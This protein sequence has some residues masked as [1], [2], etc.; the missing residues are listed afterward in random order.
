[1][2]SIW[3]KGR[4]GVRYYLDVVANTRLRGAIRSRLSAPVRVAWTA[5][6]GFASVDPEVESVAC[7]AVERMGDAGL[8]IPVGVPVELNDPRRLWLEMRSSNAPDRRRAAEFNRVPLDRVF[9]RADV[10]I[11]P[12]TPNRPHGHA[13]PGE[14]MS[15][16]LTW[17]FNLSGHPAITI[18]VGFTTDGLPVGLQLVAP[19]GEEAVLI[20]L[21]VASER[22][23]PPMMPQAQMPA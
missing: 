7:A 2:S 5:T 9:G 22:L 19:H 4:H 21:A 10:L 18:P 3:T 13:G 12:T 15:T 8:L 17:A 23:A 14:T 6:L 16:S 11:T 1:M 20:R